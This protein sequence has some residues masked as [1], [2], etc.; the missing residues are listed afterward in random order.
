MLGE[1][2]FACFNF[3]N[4]NRSLNLLFL[5]IALISPLLKLK[6]TTKKR[7]CFADIFLILLKFYKE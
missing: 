5:L 4:F 7:L 6:N 3:F 1:D 2:S